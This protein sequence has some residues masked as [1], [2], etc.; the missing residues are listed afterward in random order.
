MVKQTSISGKEDAADASLD[1][2]AKNTKEAETLGNLYM[3]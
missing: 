1:T 3:L 2:I